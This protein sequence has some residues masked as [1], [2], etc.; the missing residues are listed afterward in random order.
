MRLVK[1]PLE[2]FVIDKPV[3]LRPRFCL[4]EYRNIAHEI[5]SRQLLSPEILV[6][7]KRIARL[8]N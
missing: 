6:D 8:E 4:S 1:L 3:N 5:E 7:W 2:G